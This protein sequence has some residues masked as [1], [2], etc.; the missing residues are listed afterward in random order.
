MTKPS[1]AEIEQRGFQAFGQ[2]A[3][4]VLLCVAIAGGMLLMLFITF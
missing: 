2:A 1:D 4:T 3:L